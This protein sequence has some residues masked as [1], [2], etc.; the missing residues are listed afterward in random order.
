MLRRELLQL[1]TITKWEIDERNLNTMNP[2]SFQPERRG[3]VEN[4]SN[5]SVNFRFLTKTSD[6][7]NFSQNI[8]SDV[9][10][11]L[12][13][14]EAPGPVCPMVNPALSDVKTSAVAILSPSRRVTSQRADSMCRTLEVNGWLGLWYWGNSVANSHLSPGPFNSSVLRSCLV[15]QYSHSPH[16]SCH[17]PRL[18]NCDWMPASFT[19]GHWTIFLSSRHPT[20]WALSQGSHTVPATPCHGSWTSAPLSAHP[21]TSGVNDDVHP[22]RLGLKFFQGNFVFQ[23]I[24]CTTFIGVRK[25][26]KTAF[27]SLENGTK[28]QKC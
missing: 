10:A 5:S 14:R 16:W 8:R 23:E 15:P 20:Y 6:I 25:K 24:Q 7:R 3:N 28:N 19:S 27:S 1:G 2:T 4:K 11:G 22:P 17:Q 21:F 9:R 18:A 12:N 26:G 13:E